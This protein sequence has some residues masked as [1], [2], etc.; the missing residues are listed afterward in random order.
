[1]DQYGQG[2]QS[3][4]SIS[5]TEDYDPF[6]AHLVFTESLKRSR[7]CDADDAEDPGFLE[8]RRAIA[9]SLKQWEEEP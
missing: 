9:V 1:M 2:F 4:K 3:A 5:E 6:L 8:R 7:P